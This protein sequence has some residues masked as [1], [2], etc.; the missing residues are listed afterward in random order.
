MTTNLPEDVYAKLDRAAGH[1]AEL[2]RVE[3][4]LLAA[5]RPRVELD[6]RGEQPCYRFRRDAPPGQVIGAAIGDVVHNLR[7]ALDYSACRLATRHC[8]AADLTKVQ[9]PFGSED[10]CLR[11]RDLRAFSGI[12]TD[13]RDRLERAR[14]AGGRA[15]H[16]LRALSNQDKHRLI[17]THFF[18]TEEAGFTVDLAGAEGTVTAPALDMWKVNVPLEDGDVLAVGHH[19]RFT[20]NFA[21][22]LS[23]SI[24][25]FHGTY[26]LSVLSAIQAKVHEALS[27]LAPAM[28]SIPK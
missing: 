11:S 5:A 9:F 13:G 15:L 12:S 10:E 17:V 3:Q 21:F 6:Q 28:G 18:Q 20:P 4:D 16:L 23:F 19:A 27:E 1:L 25:G 2:A 14:T 26:R 22:M 24:D 8:A 7:C